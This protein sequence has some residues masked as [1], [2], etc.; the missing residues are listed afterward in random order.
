MGIEIKTTENI[1]G[2]PGEGFM[3]TNTSLRGIERGAGKIW[4]LALEG[5]SQILHRERNR[6]DLISWLFKQK[7]EFFIAPT[8]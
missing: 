1:P 5:S 8:S 6:K 7:D 3:V 4:V 2:Y